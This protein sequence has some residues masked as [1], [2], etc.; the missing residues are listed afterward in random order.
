M[1]G[2]GGPAEHWACSPSSDAILMLRGSW[3]S[4][5]SRQ[6]LVMVEKD[7]CEAEALETLGGSD[8]PSL[9]GHHGARVSPLR[10]GEPALLHRVNLKPQWE[11]CPG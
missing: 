11:S 3:G 8:G 10:R 1:L 2:R 5:S 9:R 6:V 4:L 7:P